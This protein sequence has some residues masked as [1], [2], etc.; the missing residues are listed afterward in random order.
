MEA[1]AAEQLSRARLLAHGEHHVAM[2]EHRTAV[3][4]GALVRVGTQIQGAIFVV[5]RLR[6]GAHIYGLWPGAQQHARHRVEHW[7]AVQHN[8]T[9]LAP[10]RT[11]ISR[12]AAEQQLSKVLKVTTVR[13]QR[14]LVLVLTS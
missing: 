1:R 11:G 5:K 3:T 12:S 6:G 10:S 13:W 4:S 7:E 14:Q 8:T 2:H 9:Q